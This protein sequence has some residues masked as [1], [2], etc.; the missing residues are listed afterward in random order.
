MVLADGPLGLPVTEQLILER[1]RKDCRTIHSHKTACRPVTTL[2][3]GFCDQVPC[4]CLPPLAI[5][6]EVFEGSL[7]DEGIGDVW[8][9]SV[10]Q[11]RSSFNPGQRAGPF[12]IQCSSYEAG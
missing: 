2:R 7:L 10:R 11:A 3:N 4:Q 1:A 8:Y 5:R 12:P 6:P 9:Q